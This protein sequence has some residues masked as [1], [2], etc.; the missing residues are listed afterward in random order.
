MPKPVALVDLEG[1]LFPEMWPSISSAI[2]DRKLDVTTRDVADYPTLMTQR[3]KLL[4]SNGVQLADRVM[5]ES[6]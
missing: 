6:W 5:P 4:R 1:V 3:L 2:G